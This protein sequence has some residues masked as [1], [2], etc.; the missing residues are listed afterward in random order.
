MA[1]RIQCKV[2][3]G[4]RVA[5]SEGPGW[6]AQGSR[7]PLQSPSPALCKLPL[8]FLLKSHGAQKRPRN[9]GDTG[10]TGEPGRVQVG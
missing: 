9:S 1:W 8:A 7:P 10:E 3:V 6:D 5:P 4:G 2:G